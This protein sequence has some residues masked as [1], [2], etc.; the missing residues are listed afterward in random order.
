[1][2]HFTDRKQD[3]VELEIGEVSLKRSTH[4]TAYHGCSVPQLLRELHSQ[5]VNSKMCVY[6][7][8]FKS[9][10]PPPHLPL[11][12]GHTRCVIQVV[13]RCLLAYR[14]GSRWSSVG[15]TVSS[16]AV[17]RDYQGYALAQDLFNAVEAWMVGNWRLDTINSDRILKARELQH[18]KMGGMSRLM[19]KGNSCK[20]GEFDT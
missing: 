16:I 6:R 3:R 10:T 19:G 5:A 14:D 18:R 11:S 13:A 1:M 9:K 17:R 8:Y 20:R 12:R 15:P 7:T 2:S 4:L